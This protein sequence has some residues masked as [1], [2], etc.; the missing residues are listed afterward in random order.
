[1]LKREIINYIE[2]HNKLFKLG[3]RGGQSRARGG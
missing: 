1:M 2:S 3:V